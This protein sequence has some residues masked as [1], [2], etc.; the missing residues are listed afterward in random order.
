MSEISDG[1]SFDRDPTRPLVAG[2]ACL[3]EWEP[4][5]ILGAAFAR[6][7]RRGEVA[8][9]R[10]AAAILGMSALAQVAVAQY[11]QQGSKLVGSQAVGTAEEGRSVAL[12]ADGGTA[13]LGG[14]MDNSLTGAA[15]V[16]TRSSGVWSQQ[17]GKL[18]GAGAVGAASQGSAV[19][20]SADG[21]TLI[22]GGFTD[23]DYKG[24]AWVFN[25]AGG[26]WSQQGDKLVGSGEVGP[27][28][29]GISAA[30]SADGNTAI[31]GGWGDNNQVGAAWVFTRAVGGWSQQG[32]KLVGTGS[33]GIS[34][35]G[36]A[37][38]ISA[39][40]DTAVVCGSDDNS[41]MG[42]TWVFTR[43]HGAWSQ[44][45]GKLVGKGAIGRAAQGSSVAISADGDTI[46]VGAVGDNSGIGAAWVFGRSGGAWSQQGAKLVGMGATDP[47]NH[48]HMGSSVALAA[49]GDIAI[50]GGEHDNGYVGAAWVFT[51]ATST[52]LQQGSKLV[53]TGAAGAAHQGNSAAVSANGST[54]IIGGFNDNSLLGA[55]W[56]F[57]ST[58]CAAPWVTVQPQSRAVRI[59]QTATLSVAAIG[60]A[61]LSYQW[62][63]GEAGYTSTPV[64]A[65]SSAFTTPSLTSAAS[66]W[67][68]VTNACGAADSGVATI[69]VASRARR[70]LH[71]LR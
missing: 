50:V 4:G 18:I 3:T 23:D 12:S 54:F 69:S 14:W 25:R 45:G 40:G 57:V 24:A 60:T 58:G 52:W 5:S 29:Q 11:V 28:Q 67:A 26:T 34:Q 56:V 71:R 68:R 49:N 2:R 15:W 39:D 19:A 41:G 61:P 37:V 42:A 65:N 48:I 70:H 6:I 36:S 35:Q 9:V 21:R 1:A 44:Q 38:A 59:G 55:A 31:V 13:V 30:I 8:M 16:F 53:G 17:G 47:N 10:I 22:V 46:L 43:S 62:Y 64:G 33:V 63:Q 32:T 66:F 20:L 51:R 7:G 27:G